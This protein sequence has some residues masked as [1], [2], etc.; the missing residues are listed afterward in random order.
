[1]RTPGVIF[2]EEANAETAGDQTQKSIYTTEDQ[3]LIKAMKSVTLNNRNI[4]PSKRDSPDETMSIQD[5]YSES[6]LTVDAE[7]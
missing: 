6:S 2:K 7:K 3:Q 4:I 1:M 5:T